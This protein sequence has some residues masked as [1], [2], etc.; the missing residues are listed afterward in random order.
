MVKKLLS[1][2]I[3]IF[4]ACF[5]AFCILE[6][7]QLLLKNIKKFNGVG[8]GL[9]VFLTFWILRKKSTLIGNWLTYFGT[10]IHEGAHEKMAFL[11]GRKLFGL[12]IDKDGS[13]HLLYESTLTINPFITLAPYFFS[14][15]S[16]ILLPF[17]IIIFKSFLFEFDTLIG[18]LLAMHIYIFITQTRFYQTDLVM[19]GKFYSVIFISIMHIIFF[20]LHIIAIGKIPLFAYFK[21]I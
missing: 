16:L 7:K 1:L 15:L 11:F 6:H 4:L 13:G 10:K 14:Y 12:N 18:F 5:I 19:S 2:I 3:I 9:L 20:G 8:I 17:R 21:S